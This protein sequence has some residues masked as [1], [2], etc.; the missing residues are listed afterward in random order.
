MTQKPR[1]DFFF[2]GRLFFFFFCWN[3]YS[4]NRRSHNLVHN[5]KCIPIIR[6]LS[7]ICRELQSTCATG[8]CLLQSGTGG[9][10]LSPPAAGLSLSC[11]CATARARFQMQKC[12]CPL[13]RGSEYPSVGMLQ[14]GDCTDTISRRVAAGRARRGRCHDNSTAGLGPKPGHHHPSLLLGSLGRRGLD[15]R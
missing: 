10:Y 6:V 15:P 4:L 14:H 11:F 8:I 7:V 12:R 1:A 5:A 2:S 9:F 13:R 3:S